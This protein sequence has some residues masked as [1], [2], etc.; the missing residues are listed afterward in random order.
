MQP[1]GELRR[2][3][4]S[5][6][7]QRHQ[8]GG[9]YVVSTCRHGFQVVSG[10]LTSLA[11]ALC[12]MQDNLDWG[13]KYGPG[14]LQQRVPPELPK[15]LLHVLQLE[16][17]FAPREMQTDKEDLQARLSRQVVWFTS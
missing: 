13:R 17:I 10:E 16:S 3:L 7:E 5:E 2:K 15:H 12:P 9:A 14:T 4:T 8:E 11:L 1:A 6:R